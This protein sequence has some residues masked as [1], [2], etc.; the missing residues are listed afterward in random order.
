MFSFSL[1]KKYCNADG[2][3]DFEINKKLIRVK[4]GETIFSQGDEVKGIYFIEHGEVKVMSDF[5][6]GHRKIM[7]FG[8]KGTII[9]HRGFSAQKYPVSA[10]A[11]TDTTLA[12]IPSGVFVGI[13]Q[14][15]ADL[16][17][18]L[19]SFLTEELQ[20]AEE[21]MKDLSVLDPRYRLAKIILRLVE[22]FGYDPADPRKLNFTPS[23]KD[24]AN[25]AGTT[26]E[27]VIRTLSHFEKTR[28]VGLVGK[29]IRVLSE[30]RLRDEI[31]KIR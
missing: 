18:Y 15:N 29:T 8:G 16:S 26:Y 9:G 12:F 14:S 30:K 11:L 28:A 22:V 10:E 19:L 21:R 7:R 1:F 17:V 24:L 2:Y 4:A 3:R 13:L 31:A 25:Y 20:E 6:K 27:T 23:R 5:S